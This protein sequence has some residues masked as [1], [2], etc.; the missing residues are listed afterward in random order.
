MK[1]AFAIPFIL[2]SQGGTKDGVI[3]GGTGQ[4]GSDPIGNAMSFTE[5]AQSNYWQT[6][7]QDYGNGDGIAD[8]AEYGM[9]WADCEF[10]YDQW[11]NAGNSQQDWEEFVVPNQW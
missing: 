10:T 9:W 4:S 5:W 2:N 11:I 3:G 1:K 6:Y 8:M 7:D